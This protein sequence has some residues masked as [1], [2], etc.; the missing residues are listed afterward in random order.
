MLRI[1]E[2]SGPMTSSEHLKFKFQTCS[3]VQGGWLQLLAPP[4]CFHNWGLKK[5]NSE[6][7]IICRHR[8]ATLSQ[9]CFFKGQ[10]DP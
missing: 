5:A 2:V 1:V 7:K 10:Y 8:D 4:I 3:N 9:D 6:V